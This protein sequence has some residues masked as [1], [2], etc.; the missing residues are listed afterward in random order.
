MAVAAVLLIE[1]FQEPSKELLGILLM[2]AL[3]ELQVLLQ[4]FL[5]LRV[6]DIAV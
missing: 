5:E 3:R 1:H 2:G 6:G 4:L